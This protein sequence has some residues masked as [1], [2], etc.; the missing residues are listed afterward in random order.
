MNKRVGKYYFIVLFLLVSLNQL[1]SQDS[2]VVSGKIVA[3]KNHPVQ[4][5][6]VSVEGM[7]A[8]PVLTDQNGGFTITVP[9]G[10]V[11]LMINP[12]GN[13]KSKRIFLNNRTELIVSL[14]EEDMKSGFDN[15][16][17]INR[18]EQRRDVLTSMKALDLDRVEYKNI[19]SVDQAFQGSV[20]GMLTTNHSG[21]P[22]QG[23]V[24]FLRG[25]NSM[26]A[27]NA[28][29]Y[30]LDGMPLEESGMFVSQ[31]DGNSYNPVSTINPSDISSVTI[32]KDPL[33]TSIYGTQASNGVVLINTLQ[34]KATQTSIN[35]SF[36]SGMNVAP[37]GFIPQLN[38]VQYK[39]LAS[40]I[41]ASSPKKEEKFEED[42]PG[43]YT[44]QEDDDYYRY[45][46]NTH[47]QNLIF[48]NALTSNAY[49]SVKGGSDI[50]K[51]GLSVGYSDRGGVFENSSFN[52]FNVLFVSDL[53]IF[54]W[55]QMKVSANL[56]NNNSYLRESAVSQHTSPIL[57]SL[58][59]P[60]ILGPYQYDE[61]GNQIELLDDVDELGTSNPL[62]IANNF[63]GENKNHRFVSSVL[64][65]ADISESMNWNTFLGINFNTLKESVFMPNKGMEEY[66]KGEPQNVS[67]QTNNHFFSFYTDNRLN[68][69]KQYGAI[70]HLN[71]SVGF[72]IH[73]NTFQLDFGESMNMPGNDQYT[74]LQSG[75]NDL[76]R[77]GG[78]NTRWNWISI[79]HQLS[80]KFQDKY[81]INTGLSVDYSSLVGNDAKTT[82][83]LHEQPY[84]VFYSIGTG[85]RIS[86]EDFLKQIPGL[87]NL[88]LRVSYGTSGNDDIGKYNSF[89]YYKES[90]YRETSGLIPGK[91]ANESL[92]Y[93]KT[94]HVNAG[95]NLSLWGARTRFT[96]DYFVRTN[97][98]MLIYEPQNSYIGYSYQPENAGAVRNMGWELSLFQRLV[99]GQ[100]FD[101]DIISTLSFLT[102]EVMDIKGEALVTPFFG[103]AFVTKEGY[104]M[105]SY[106]GYKFEGVYSTFEEA[107]QANLVN[108]KGIP[109]IA[110]DAK[111]K[112]ISGPDNEPDG[113]IDD[114][115]RMNLG[116][117][118]PDYF[119]SFLNS[120]Q[121]K[122]WS[123][124]MMIQFVYGHELFNYTRYMNERMVDLS[125]QSQHVLKRWQQEGDDTDVPRALW[126][127]PV[128]N[129]D[130]SSRWIED[131]TYIRLKN[132]RLGYTIPEEFLVF[133]NADFYVSATN[134]FTL[135][136]YLGYD[137]EFSY[138]YDPMKQGIDY[139]LMPQ[140]RQ[141]LFGI[142]FGL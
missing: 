19:V 14:A 54:S 48:S 33:A 139:G 68:F 18:L 73:T 66:Y 53:N 4:D 115:D 60:P 43:L 25:I 35:F 77:L 94:K 130:F 17:L 82:F 71:T 122:R 22:G 20:P 102:N 42:Y 27:S 32:L 92:K 34:P 112:D 72:R 111:F 89:N 55:L 62:A 121:Y 93:E 30:I 12:I 141:F 142:K 3:R 16:Q 107:E 131:G 75:Q 21:M 101:W 52:R 8:A 135:D 57:T 140:F 38:D 70:H 104:P 51:Y 47:W 136:K 15:V 58:A 84:G 39:S 96:A 44:N 91:L 119:G 74:S 129:S 1:F 50:A 78:D 99:D 103:G 86:E 125:N 10:E 76:M 36:Q 6:S 126:K 88:L 64:G 63:Q 116:S 65:K 100:K 59:K 80:Y 9:T 31:L 117:P 83:H 114:Y 24:S 40:E 7:N 98:D 128:G 113:V 132:I 97:E 29:L 124:D 105:N 138:S 95:I 67:Q 49:L 85:W 81:I 137:P 123:L 90:R 11:W 118:V 79:Y 5:V 46:H 61:N 41:L 13:Y 108:N 28:P 87:E 110:G 37:D 120:F 133:K 69:K 134:L 2:L 23:T 106:Y 109:F 56:T 127:D 26:N 45:M